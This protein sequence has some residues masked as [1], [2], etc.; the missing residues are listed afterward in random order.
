MDLT[1]ITQKE[2][3][4]KGLFSIE[5]IMFCYMLFTALLICVHWSELAERESMLLWRAG[6]AAATVLLV[7]AY[8]LMPNRITSTLRMLFQLSLLSFWYPE[9]YKF[10]TLVGN[11]DHLFA[12]AEQ[13]LFGCQPSID[14]SGAMPEYLWCELFNLGYFSYFPMIAAV[15]LTTLFIKYRRFEKTAF[16]VLCSFFIYYIIYIFLPVA[17]PQYYFCAIGIDN[18]ESGHFRE[19]GS[20]FMTHTEMLP[21]PGRGGFFQYLV[22]V[23]HQSERPT[24][25]FPS[26]HVGVSTILLILAGK[27]SKKLLFWLLPFYVLLCLATVYI[28][29][30]YLI[31]I[32]AGLLSAY[33]IYKLAHWLYYSKLFYSFNPNKHRAHRN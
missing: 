27:T 24:A 16:I 11:L 30:H 9:T 20:W 25:A 32:I 7:G 21:A 12:G 8:R 1:T 31:D 26:S 29:A 18:A 10:C 4:R 15:V 19:I 33:P 22:D 13:T 23:A 3:L 17:G 14:F 5:K 28:Q 2:K 6:I